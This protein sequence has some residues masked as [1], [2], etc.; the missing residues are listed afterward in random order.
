MR[1]DFIDKLLKKY[2]LKQKSVLMASVDNNENVFLQPIKKPAINTS[3]KEVVN[4]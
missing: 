2:D 4:E 1:N 3:V